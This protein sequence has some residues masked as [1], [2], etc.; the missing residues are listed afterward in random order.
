VVRREAARQRA[1]DLG[2]IVAELRREGAV[3]L[4]E[5]A[6]GLNDQSIPAPRGGEW[7][8]GQVKRLLAHLEAAEPQVRVPPR[9][10]M[11]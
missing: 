6:R 7:S 9:R 4:G 3:S 11:A 1:A 10:R 8:A 2:P 5:L